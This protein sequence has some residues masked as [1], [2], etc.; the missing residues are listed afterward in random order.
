[1]RQN[2]DENQIKITNNYLSS[3]LER[4]SLEKDE[5]ISSLISANDK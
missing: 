1:M 3:R 5:P 4:L 2:E